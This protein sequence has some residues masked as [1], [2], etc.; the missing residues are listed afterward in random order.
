MALLL[1]KSDTISGPPLLGR[2]PSWLD[3][4]LMC[5]WSRLKIFLYSNS[6]FSACVQCVVCCKWVTYTS[7]TLFRINSWLKIIAMLIV[8]CLMPLQKKTLTKN[9][10]SA[11]FVASP[12]LLNF[13]C[14][15]LLL[16]H[17]DKSSKLFGPTNNVM[18]SLLTFRIYENLSTFFFSVAFFSSFFHY[19]YTLIVMTRF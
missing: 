4:D 19:F 3:F 9:I 17:S 18:M 8:C 10:I 7:R 1:H 15:S 16:T 13:L 2:P 14:T 6:H 5:V 12:L 11:V